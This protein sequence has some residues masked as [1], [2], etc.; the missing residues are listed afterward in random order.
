VQIVQELKKELVLHFRQVQAT[1]LGTF[2]DPLRKEEAEKGQVTLHLFS[3]CANYL[4]ML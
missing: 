4:I 1:N 3:N 2:Q